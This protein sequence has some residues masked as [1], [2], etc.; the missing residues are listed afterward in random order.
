MSGGD[1]L[2]VLRF[3]CEE[4]MDTTRIR[5]Q[6]SEYAEK[7]RDVFQRT[8]DKE[9]EHREIEKEEIEE[10]ETSERTTC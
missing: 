6:L 7:M 10:L 2:K 8:R 9:T 4:A 5:D 3:L 1:K